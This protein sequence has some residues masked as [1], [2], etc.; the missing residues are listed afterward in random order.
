[1]RIKE[2]CSCGASMEVE[3]A[4]ALA[5]KYMEKWRGEHKHQFRSY[6]YGTVLGPYSASYTNGAATTQ[7]DMDGLM[8]G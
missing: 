1:M 2:T 8:N 4:S 3:A 5:E 7:I 6:G